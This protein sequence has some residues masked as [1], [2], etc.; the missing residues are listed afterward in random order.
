V[1]A[2]LIDLSNKK[3]V[4]IFVSGGL[5]GTDVMI[6]KY[7]FAEKMWRENWRFFAKTTAGF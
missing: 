5:P 4:P 2:A 7:I 6:E 3:I 1:S